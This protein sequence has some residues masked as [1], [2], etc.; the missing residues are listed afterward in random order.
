MHGGEAVAVRR[1]PL[2]GQGQRVGVAVDADDPGQRA[3]REDRLA[4]A[5][6]PEGG[7][8]EDGA[9]VVERG[10]QKSDDPVQEDRDVG[11]GRHRAA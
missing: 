9:V 5:A 8:D 10:C 1:E 3:L 7:V 6:E 4:V 2:A 11:G